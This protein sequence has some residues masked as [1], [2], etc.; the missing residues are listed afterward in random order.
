M[1]ENKA[2]K[3][4]RE[5]NYNIK[6]IL[7]SDPNHESMVID[8]TKPVIDALPYDYVFPE[9]EGDIGIAY[10]II[11]V[12]EQTSAPGVPNYMHSPSL[13]TPRQFL[14]L[15]QDINHVLEASIVNA[16][17]L[18]AVKKL[19]ADVFEKHVT[20]CMAGID[21]VLQKSLS[22]SVI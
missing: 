11:G 4:L 21:K 9:E 15:I 16:K 2:D 14:F 7:G 22:K 1:T 19:V 17:Q 5:V 12:L 3:V 18:D 6:L 20:D 8:I 10:K 13:R